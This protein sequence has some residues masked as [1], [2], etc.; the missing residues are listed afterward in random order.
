MQHSN[1]DLS[2]NYHLQAEGITSF[3]SNPKCI[4]F[5]IGW[6]FVKTLCLSWATL[7]SKNNLL[8]SALSFVFNLHFWVVF[9]FSWYVS[10]IFFRA[11]MCACMW[12][13]DR[14]ED[15]EGKRVCLSKQVQHIYVVV[16]HTPL[17]L[18]DSSQLVL[19][20]RFNTIEAF[21]IQHIAK[22]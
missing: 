15:G 1:Q 11:E 18:F 17:Y 6:Y 20:W 22:D 5:C 8:V 14:R 9:Q 19:I 13:G 16:R 10:T 4:E 21:K 7:A 2:L 12:D 3:Q